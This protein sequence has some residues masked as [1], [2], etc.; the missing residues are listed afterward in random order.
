MSGDQETAPAMLF[1]GIEGGGGG[2]GVGRQYDVHFRRLH[3]ARHEHV[4]REVVRGRVL[5]QHERLAAQIGRP[6]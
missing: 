5:G 6:S 2:K 1:V 3:A 4:Q